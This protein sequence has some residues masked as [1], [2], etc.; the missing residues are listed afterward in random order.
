MEKATNKKQKSIL[1]MMKLTGWTCYNV[2]QKSSRQ[3]TLMQ[4]CFS[5]FKRSSSTFTSGDPRI[6]EQYLDCLITST[7]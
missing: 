2:S 5:F 1:D 3:I 6:F 7:T 4:V